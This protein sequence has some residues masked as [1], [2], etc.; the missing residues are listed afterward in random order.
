[1]Q[2]AQAQASQ[3]ADMSALISSVLNG[4]GG[5]GIKALAA[6]VKCLNRY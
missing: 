5:S 4:S 2:Q 6:D 1:M 3:P